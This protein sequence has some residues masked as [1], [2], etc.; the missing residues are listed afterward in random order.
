MA[1]ET[2]WAGWKYDQNLVDIYTRRIEKAFEAALADA[3]LIISEWW[4]GSITM[5]RQGVVDTVSELVEK[6]L[7]VTL[8]NLWDEAWYLGS[9]SA[10]IAISHDHPDF[11]DWRPGKGV[12]IDEAGLRHLL[13]AYGPNVLK[14][15]ASTRMEQLSD[16]LTKVARSRSGPEG[17]TSQL[18]SVLN[19]QARA[20]MIASTEIRRAISMAAMDKYKQ[21]GIPLK[22]WL[23]P[24]EGACPVCKENESE[25][26]IPISSLFKSGVLCGPQHPYCRCVQVPGQRPLMQHSIE[27]PPG[28]L[29]ADEPRLTQFPAEM[30]PREARRLPGHVVA[31]IQEDMQKGLTVAEATKIALASMPKARDVPPNSSAWGGGSG[32]GARSM[33][34]RSPATTG[35]D[36]SVSDQR[37]GTSA[38]KPSAGGEPPKWDAPD[39]EVEE[40]E[41]DPDSSDQYD[42]EGQVAFLQSREANTFSHPYARIGVPGGAPTGPSHGTQQPTG[43]NFTIPRN[44]PQTAGIAQTQGGGNDGNYPAFARGRPPN[45]V[46][47]QE[48]IKV[49]GIC[50]RANDT[51][52]VLMRQREMLDEE[53]PSI[54]KDASDL[55]DPNPVEGEHV[56]NQMLKNYPPHSVEWIKK[57]HW[58][59]PILIPHERIDYD[60]K[61]KWAA[62]HQPGAVDRF[63]KDIQAGTGRTHPVVMVQQPHDYKLNVIDGHHRTLAY[64]KLG[65]KVKAYVGFVHTDRGPWD[66]TH[67]SQFHQG[68]DPGNKKKDKAAGKW[69]F[70]GGHLDKGENSLDAACREWEEETGLKMPGGRVTGTWLSS[71]RHY[72]GFIHSIDSEDSLPIRSIKDDSDSR[73]LAWFNPEDMRDDPTIR[74]EILDDIE[75][76]LTAIGV[77]KAARRTSPQRQIDTAR[78]RARRYQHDRAIEHAHMRYAELMGPHHKEHSQAHQ[79]ALARYD[80]TVRSTEQALEHAKNHA[81]HAK[82]RV[83]VARSAASRSHQMLLDARGKLD[84]DFDSHRELLRHIKDTVES[85][86]QIRTDAEIRDGHAQGRLAEAKDDHDRVRNMAT[87]AMN[88]E[89]QEADRKLNRTERI[90]GRQRDDAIAAARAVA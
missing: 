71:D 9:R 45:S 89:C 40:D 66:E 75:E 81:N 79:N 70:P 28:T 7:G 62:S 13:N 54:R 4:R 72:R 68:S 12:E 41:Y 58:I 8:R 18:E 11:G 43:D 15:I 64:K 6:H 87:E 60:D 42:I 51:G 67:S 57:A 38:P 85:A 61:D 2:E 77:R 5:T 39:D 27:H 63:A 80:Q 29:T 78:T 22:Q 32:M 26:S 49:A 24:P 86:Q 14:G 76:I 47:K 69:E 74:D 3:S 19:V 52:R 56:Y 84:P 55:H 53:R 48:K 25:G 59:G 10:A 31:T 16:A 34:D 37:S 90:I 1:D 35:P 82:K 21:D 30:F 50:I 46:G 44:I 36:R 17:I 23:T 73:A 83:E 33:P 65:Q 20:P 88:A